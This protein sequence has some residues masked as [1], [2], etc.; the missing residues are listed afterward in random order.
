MLIYRSFKSA[1]ASM[2]LEVLS[3]SAPIE[4]RIDSVVFVS[5]KL[6]TNAIGGQPFSLVVLNIG[7][8]NFVSN[9]CENNGASR[10][11]RSF[12]NAPRQGFKHVSKVVSK[13]EARAFREDCEK[14]VSPFILSNNGQGSGIN[15]HAQCEGKLDIEEEE[16]DCEGKK[17]EAHFYFSWWFLK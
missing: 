3:T 14:L 15:V 8:T 9:P 4:N 13:R 10:D 7:A 6:L 5:I 1:S 11:I 17:I 12:F 2:P 16:E